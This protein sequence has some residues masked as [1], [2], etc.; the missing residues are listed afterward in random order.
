MRSHLV[1]ALI[2]L[3]FL[4]IQ[5]DGS[6]TASRPG[7]THNQTAAVIELNIQTLV[8]GNAA[9]KISVGEVARVN[10]L[11]AGDGA[12]NKRA[13]VVDG[14]LAQRGNK[15][16]R[17][18]R[19]DVL[20][21]VTGEESAAVGFPELSLDRGNARC[22]VGLLLGDAGDDIQPCDDSPDTVL[23]TDVVG[24]GT[25]ALFTADGHLLVV[26]EVA[27][28]FPACRDF[29]ALQALGLG[30]AVHGA[31]GG[32]RAGEAVNAVLLEPGD[33][34]CV[35]SDDGE[36]VARGDEGVGAVDH[37][38]VTVAVGSGAEV[39]AVLVDGL[40]EL[41][42]VHE[43]R[44][45]VAA[46]EIGLGDAVHGAAGGKAELVDEDVDAVGAC[47]T[48]HA[49]EED[50]EIGVLLEEAAD[51]VEVEDL[52]HHGDVVLG[53]VDN[54]HLEGAIAA[55]ADCGGVNL[56]EVDVLVGGEGLRDLVDLIGD[57]FRGG[58]A[59]GKVVLDAK[60]VIR[61]YPVS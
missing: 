33:K 14:F 50:L 30:D 56:G 58:R 20:V 59:I 6:T 61:T 49:V 36:R 35:V 48:V 10:D 13:L 15:F 21:V 47:Y 7:Q 31:G 28:E 19:I 22:F 3:I 24:A 1:L 4:D 2:A 45:W 11:S 57:L 8:L 5:P 37:V 27:E 40:D 38:A 29:V 17:A 25:E 43:V 54:F 16:V 18:V 51:E 39:D 52:L 55:G 26:E 41:V 32:H 42:R 34:L 44:V 60:V 53:R 9:V 12:A 46:A 23:L